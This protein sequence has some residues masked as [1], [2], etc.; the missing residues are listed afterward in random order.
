MRLRLFILGLVVATVAV[1]GVVWWPGQ[2]VAPPPAPV[3]TAQTPEEPAAAVVPAPT[4]TPAPALSAAPEPLPTT[5]APV[6]EAVRLPALDESDRYV[7]ER[8]LPSPSKLADWLNRDDLVR[9]FAVVMD[10]AAVGDLPRRQ[11]AFL[12]PAGPFPVVARSND[13]FVMDPTGY[14]RYARFVETFTSVPPEVAAALL[15]TLAPLLTQALHELGG[16]SEEPLATLR[17]AIGMVLATPELDTAVELVRPKVV[18]QFADPALEALPPLQKQ[19]I[20]MGPDHLR[21]I[22]AYLRQVDA[23]L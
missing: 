14:A 4:P 1:A 19:L 21:R 10:N 9:R 23:A 11:L 15:T 7:R 20:R 3:D 16:P 8:L 5:T 6:K 17:D 12:A 2:E 22:K 18:Y 13:R